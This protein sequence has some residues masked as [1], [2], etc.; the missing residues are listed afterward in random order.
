MPGAMNV[1]SVAASAVLRTR[2]PLGGRSNGYHEFFHG[3]S[4]THDIPSSEP[5]F[6]EM[7]DDAHHGAQRLRG[8]LWKTEFIS[9]QPSD[10]G[11]H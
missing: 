1:S 10:S 2:R 5:F 7:A 6:E 4:I 8:R 11:L 3:G 9:I